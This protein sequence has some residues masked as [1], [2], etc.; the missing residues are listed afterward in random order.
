M[1]GLKR[2]EM[3]GHH[4]TGLPEF[5]LSVAKQKLGA[6]C[7]SNIRRDWTVSQV[8]PRCWAYKQDGWICARGF[9][10]F[11][12]I[13]TFFSCTCLQ[14]SLPLFLCLQELLD[15]TTLDWAVVW[16]L[17]SRCS[18]WIHASQGYFEGTTCLNYLRYFHCGSVISTHCFFIWGI[19][20]KVCII[21]VLARCLQLIQHLPCVCY[22]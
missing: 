5:F 17:C 16:T 20:L 14:V 4:N 19:H 2:K 11:Q 21:K 7:L 18:S 8:C 13:F 10:D 9:S 6:T 1:W 15:C 12:I 22:L 3:G